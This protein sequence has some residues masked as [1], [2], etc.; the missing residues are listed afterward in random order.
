MADLTAISAA[1]GLLPITE[2]A[3][4]LSEAVHRHI[5]SVMPLAPRGWAD[6]PA[7]GHVA[8]TGGVR[9]IWAGPERYFVFG[10]APQ[11]L[12]AAIC[13]QTDAWAALVLEGPSARDVLARLTP[14]DLR[15]ACFGPGQ[16]AQT[17]LG[18]MTATVICARAERY[19]ILIFRSMAHTAVHELATAMRHVTARA[20]GGG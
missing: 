10:P 7:P 15:E 3:L 16:C 13:D 5:T 18:H 8:E 14:L 11:G 19:E 4:T 12:D 1:D 9:A 6:A 20:S 2:G 17:L